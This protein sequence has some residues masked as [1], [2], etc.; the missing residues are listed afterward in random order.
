MQRIYDFFLAAILMLAAVIPASADSGGVLLLTDRQITFSVVG[1]QADIYAGTAPADQ[2]QWESA[3]PDV[4]QVS[5]DGRLTA[6]GVGSSVITARWQ[7]SELTCLAECLAQ[8][9]QELFELPE[10]KLRTPKRIPAE[11]EF[12]PTAFFSDAVIIGDSLTAGMM[13]HE[14]RTNLLGHP[15]FLCRKNIGIYN[16]ATYRINLFYRGIEYSVEDAV[17]ASGAKKAFFMLGVND[18]AYQ[19]VEEALQRY[20]VIIDRVREKS[21]DVQIYLQT[22]PPRYAFPRMFTQFNEKYDCFNVKLIEMAQRKDCHVVDLA[23]RCCK[24]T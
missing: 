5:Q 8:N 16:F 1:E 11:V 7:D 24:A 22:C 19:S 2:V 18:L 21:P 13:A 17:A 23:T 4:I 12:D 3:A 10:E 9:R 6:V 20:E 15:V 14:V